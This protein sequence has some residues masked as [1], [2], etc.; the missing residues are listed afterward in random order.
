M[1]VHLCYVFF[2]RIFFKKPF[3]SQIVMWESLEYI[4]SNWSRDFTH[5]RIEREAT[6]CRKE[7]EDTEGPEK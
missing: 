4:D 7:K 3:E 2:T 6:S 1:M 5:S